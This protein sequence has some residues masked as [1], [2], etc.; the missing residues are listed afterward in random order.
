[1]SA[2]R[3]SA[4]LGVRD[5]GAANNGGLG[6]NVPPSDGRRNF[7][8]PGFAALSLGQHP[9]HGGSVRSFHSVEFG[10]GLARL[11]EVR[12][13]LRTSTWLVGGTGGDRWRRGLVVGQSQGPAAD[14][15][16]PSRR[17]P[18][19]RRT[20]ARVHVM[21]I[22]AIGRVPPFCKGNLIP[23]RRDAVFAAEQLVRQESAEA[24]DFRD[25]HAHFPDGRAEFPRDF[26]VGREGADVV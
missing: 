5:A 1:M 14:S 15:A 9:R 23:Q 22:Q 13:A 20:E 19:R 6:A 21:R 10:G 17:S 26:A 2:H 16:P 25:R 3:C 8:Q 7:S 12:L 18:G 24:D 11:V 4:P